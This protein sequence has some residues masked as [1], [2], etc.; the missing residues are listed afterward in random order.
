MQPSIQKLVSN[1]ASECLAHLGDEAVHSEAYRE[2][3]P[4]VLAALDD[5]EVSFSDS[6]VDKALLKEALE[7]ME[8]RFTEETSK[9]NKNVC[10][11]L[12]YVSHTNLWCCSLNRSLQLPQG[13]LHTFALYHFWSVAGLL[14]LKQWRYQQFATR[15]LYSLLQRDMVPTPELARFFLE[16]CI[17]PHTATR[18]IAV[19]CAHLP[20]YLRR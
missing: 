19:R 1:C 4:R 15:I 9:H 5:L 18:A 13:R 12:L 17:S 6:L 10:H 7:K 16:Q 11:S 14:M 20:L 3:I 8:A 2:D